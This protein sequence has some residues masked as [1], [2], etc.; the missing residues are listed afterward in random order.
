[1]MQ[2]RLV[3]AGILVEP[4]R[5]AAHANSAG[6]NPREVSI[7]TTGLHSCGETTAGYVVSPWLSTLS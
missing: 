4:E 3:S 7:I 2:C 1:M 5:L 6:V